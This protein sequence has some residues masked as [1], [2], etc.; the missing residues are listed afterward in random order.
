MFT[1]KD[2]STKSKQMSINLQDHAF[3]KSPKLYSK[4]SDTIRFYLSW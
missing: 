4:H 2:Y 3:R 1:N